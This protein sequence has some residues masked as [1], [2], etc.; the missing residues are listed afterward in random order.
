MGMQQVSRTRLF[1]TGTIYHYTIRGMIWCT[2]PLEHTQKHVPNSNFWHCKKY[3]D[4]LKQ[5]VLN[6]KLLGHLDRQKF[7]FEFKHDMPKIQ[8][9]T[10]FAITHHSHDFNRN[11]KSSE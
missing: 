4:Y 2:A 8:K 10:K 1:L 7:K 3:L 9:M 11:L 6:F 5:D